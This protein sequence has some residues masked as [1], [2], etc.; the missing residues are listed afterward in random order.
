M[1]QHCVLLST[2]GIVHLR[3]HPPVKKERTRLGV[4][5]WWRV[6]I[7][8]GLSTADTAQVLTLIG[9]YAWLP[10]VRLLCAVAMLCR[11]AGC[12]VLVL[13]VAWYAGAIHGPVLSVCF[14]RALGESMPS[15]CCQGRVVPLEVMHNEVVTSAQWEVWK[16]SKSL[17]LL[18]CVWFPCVLCMCCLIVCYILPTPS[19]TMYAE[20]CTIFYNLYVIILSCA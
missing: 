15:L 6:N 2:S 19:I 11:I 8:M 13:G 16:H 10:Y 14:H 20:R 4:I 1:V 12:W 3:R 7:I 5:S 9:K 17:N 18:Q